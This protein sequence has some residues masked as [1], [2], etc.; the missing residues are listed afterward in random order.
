MVKLI[1]ALF[2]ATAVLVGCGDDDATDADADVELFC[3]AFQAPTVPGVAG[4]TQSTLL[5]L[6]QFFRQLDDVAPAPIADDVSTVVDGLEERVDALAEF[7]GVEGEA[8][9]DAVQGATDVDL[10]ALAE[11]IDA[12]DEYASRNC[13]DVG[14]E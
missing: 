9:L 14:D 4:T 3:T 10:E 11:S 12:V 5:D 2:V 1:G 6:L 8:A 7:D 13:E